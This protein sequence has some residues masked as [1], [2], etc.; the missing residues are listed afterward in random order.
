M[1]RNQAGQKAQNQ[2]IRC[3]DSCRG[4]NFVMPRQE[5]IQRWESRFPSLCSLERPVHLHLC[6]AEGSVLSDNYS[7]EHT[8]V[9]R[10]SGAHL[11]S[12]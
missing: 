12:C 3:I 5:S 1:A 6:C 9:L 4:I 7:L 11:V 10:A 8:L 2:L